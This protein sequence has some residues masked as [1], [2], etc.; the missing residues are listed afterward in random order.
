MYICLC[1][2]LFVFLLLCMCVLCLSVMCASMNWSALINSPFFFFL[3]FFKSKENDC[4]LCSYTCLCANF[5]FVLVL[6]IMCAYEFI[7]SNL[8]VDII[9]I[10]FIFSERREWLCALFLYYARMQQ[11]DGNKKFKELIPARPLPVCDFR[12][13]LNDHLSDPSDDTLTGSVMCFCLL[14]FFFS[15]ELLT[16]ENKPQIFFFLLRFFFSFLYFT[17]TCF[18][19]LL[20]R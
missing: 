7:N 14:F 5:S 11:S 2:F 13:F 4:A 19:T 20:R 6:A 8:L 15:Y 9:I 1:A 12:R 17:H 3:F 10:N 16:R 18:P